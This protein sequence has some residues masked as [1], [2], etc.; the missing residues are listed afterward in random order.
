MKLM[1]ALIVITIVFSSL[2]SA[3]V[4]KRERRSGRLIIKLKE[5]G[6]QNNK[7]LAGTFEELSKK[8]GMKKRRQHKRSG[9]IEADHEMKGSMTE[10]QMAAELMASGAVEFA[11][12][13][14]LFE[15]AAMPDDSLFDQQWMHKVM[16]TPEA[17]DHTIGDSGI[18]AA[19]CDSGVDADHPDL[20]GRV[21]TGYN[22]VTGSTITTPHTTHGTKVAGLIAAAGNNGIGMAGMAWKTRILP[23]RITTSSKGSAF[24]SDMA[25]CIEWAAD[26]GAKVINLSFTGFASKTIDNAAQYA[27]S[28]GALLFMAAGNQGNN[29]SKSPDYKS[30]LLV[31]ATTSTDSR[32][33]YS[34]YGTPIDLVAPGHQVLTTSPGGGYATINGTSF[35]SP[36]AAGLG[37]LVWSINP[38]F[39]PDQIESILTSTTDDIGPSSTFG[40]GRI[41]ASRAIA[42]ALDLV[43]FDRAPVAKISL[44]KGRYVVGQSLKLSASESSDDNGISKY[45]WAFSDGSVFEGMN[46]EHSFVNA[47]VY[48][49]TLTV[50]DTTGQMTSTTTEI[51]VN[52]TA[53]ILM[54]VKEIKMTVFYT[55]SYSRTESNITIVNEEGNLVP[56]ALVTVDINSEQV[57]AV[58]N[59][60][61]IARIKGGRKSKKYRHKLTVL[62]VSE[63]EHE[64]DSSLNQE[65]SDTI[66]VR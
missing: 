25:E 66:R 34:N 55:R 18:I 50:W 56:N 41:N 58:T 13:D 43:D 45:H 30:F 40:F 9:L 20:K 2:A 1:T 21:L 15:E 7:R 6:R 28:K 52:L 65:T 64:Y 38:D 54:S 11:E 19:V 24:L 46:I 59:S 23:I 37:A 61:G 31:G 8:L 33:R 48:T 10:E 35:S 26:N 27:R 47:G 53:T 16:K 29:V 57:S 32:A 3:D 36:V 17:W 60:S 4:K 39:T 5:P 63:D 12:P 22:P 49:V 14:Y 44:P 42:S 51:K 62:S